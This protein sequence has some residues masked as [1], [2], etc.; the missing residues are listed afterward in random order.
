MPSKRHRLAQRR[1][2]VGHTQESLAEKL[3]VDRTTVV[4]WERGESEPQPWVRPR[5]A[6]ALGV[7]P[8]ELSGLLADVGV[9]ETSGAG[10]QPRRGLPVAD[11]YV[12]SSASRH[13]PAQQAPQEAHLH[14]VQS[15]RMADRR[16]GGGHLYAAVSAYL[17]GGIDH[18]RAVDAEQELRPLLAAA[19]SLNEMA[20]WMAHD[21]AATAQARRHLSEALLLA[22]QSSDRQLLAQV[23]ASLSHLASH[24][25]DASH[26]LSHAR[27][28]LE[29]LRY[30]PSHGRLQARLLAMQARGFAVAGQ[31]LEATRAL[32]DAEAA[33]HGPITVASEWLS[34][35]DSTSFAI[36]AARCFL[37]IGDLSEAHRRL[38]D[39]L[40]S[41]SA[42]RIRSTAFAQLM[43]VT[44]LI[45]KE[46]IDEACALTSQTL[47]EITSLGSSMIL[48]HLVHTSI[49]LRSQAK[50]YVEIPALVERLQQAILERSWIGTMG[51]LRV[52]AAGAGRLDGG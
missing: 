16:V 18:E 51:A 3:G 44:V 21:A 42:D 52:G 34:P 30:A 31:P 24:H 45:G 48:D 40:A 7:L 29:H 26:A 11:A 33:L 9:A 6:D 5:L 41:R 1:K 12:G 23:C 15:L 10:V 2:T 14:F 13:G 32:A 49:L 20:G 39:A 4:R 19:A 38:Q 35:F 17:A 50:T 25:G 37:R 27:N 22:T 36:E 47:D 43:L 28:G 8:D 46:R